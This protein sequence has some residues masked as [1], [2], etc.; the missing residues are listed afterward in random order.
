MSVKSLEMAWSLNIIY[1]SRSEP[2]DHIICE[3][4]HWKIFLSL[5]NQT[6]GQQ[7]V[8]GHLWCSQP[9]TFSDLSPGY[10]S[11]L[12]AI[13]TILAILYVYGKGRVEGT[14]SLPHTFL[15]PKD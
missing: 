11:T 1:Y 5:I 10:H 6:C 2:K 7:E 13:Y 3:I 14:T 12:P 9:Y 4:Y 8:T 15:I